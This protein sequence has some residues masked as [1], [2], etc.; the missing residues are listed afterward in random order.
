MEIKNVDVTKENG[1]T[2]ARLSNI[3][4]DA[5]ALRKSDRYNLFPDVVCAHHNHYLLSVYCESKIAKEIMKEKAFVFPDGTSQQGIGDIAGVVMKVGHKI[6]ALKSL[7][8]S[9]ADMSD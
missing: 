4:S 1:S 7:K 8:I 5:I 3:V 6:C 2:I 9:K